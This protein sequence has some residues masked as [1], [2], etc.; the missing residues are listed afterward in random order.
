[1][2][3]VPGTFPVSVSD[4]FT[5]GYAPCSQWLVDALNTGERICYN[6]DPWF[7]DFSIRPPCPWQCDQPRLQL[8]DTITM[9]VKFTTANGAEYWRSIAIKKVAGSDSTCN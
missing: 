4:D 8:N 2:I 7:S 5:P 6:T 1:M 3:H 9:T